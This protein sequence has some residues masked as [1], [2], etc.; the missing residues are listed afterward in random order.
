M[1]ATKPAKLPPTADPRCG[2]PSG[3]TAHRRRSESPC[4][5]CTEAE[6]VRS[7]TRFACD[8]G[9]RARAYVQ[10]AYARHRKRTPQQ[11]DA[12]FARLRPKGKVCRGCGEALPAQS[13]ARANRANDGRQPYCDENGCRQR[14]AKLTRDAKLR[15]HWLSRGLPIDTCAYCGKR[16]IEHIDHFYPSSRG[17]PNDFDN[18]VGS[19]GPCNLTKSARLPF[20]WLA[21]QHPDR[22]DFFHALFN[23]DGTPKPL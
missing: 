5:L 2:T 7:R 15:A 12:E 17:G 19:C 3:Y 9:T 21:N 10:S 23:E 20:E 16:P 4:P 1:P 14:H 6:R 18:Y 13:F 8:G 22:L 11:A